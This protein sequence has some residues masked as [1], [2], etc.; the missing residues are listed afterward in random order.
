MRRVIHAIV[1]FTEDPEGSRATV[2]KLIETA[3]ELEGQWDLR[4]EPKRRIRTNQQNKWY[5]S[6]IVDP[7]Y[8]FLAAQDYDVTKP[9]DAH[10]I[11]AE[12]FLRVPIVV[13]QETQEAVGWR[14]RSTKELTTVEFSEY[15][16]RC[17]AWLADFFHIDTQDPPIG[18]SRGTKSR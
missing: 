1:D 9:N 10:E 12:K 17:R 5:W 4:L 7:F 2:R 6:C 15:C 3:R 16:E 18:D 8:D 13:D 14:T 11:L